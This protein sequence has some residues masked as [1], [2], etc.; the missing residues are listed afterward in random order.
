MLV[1]WV[2]L[3]QKHWFID[4]SPHEDMANVLRLEGKHKN[5]LSSITYTYKAAYTA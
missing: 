1:G 4:S 3:K 2:F 5:A